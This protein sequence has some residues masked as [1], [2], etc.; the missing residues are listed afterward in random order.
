V[1]EYHVVH[2][3]DV[4]PAVVSSAVVIVVDVGLLEM[5]SER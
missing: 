4:S 2:G 3:M 1:D 5:V